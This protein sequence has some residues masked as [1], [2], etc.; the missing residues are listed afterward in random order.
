[1]SIFDELRTATATVA[2]SAGAAVVRVGRAG[3]RGAGIVTAPG[4]VVTS[5]HNVRGEELTVTFPGGREE[6]GAVKGVDADGDLAVVA[7]DTGDVAP[8][9][10]SD[11]EIGLGDTV[12]APVVPLGG[13]EVRVTVG[14]VSARQAAFRG[15][16]GRLISDAVE[17]TAPLGRG[18]SGGPLVDPEGRLVAINTH[19]PGGGLYLA[20]PVTADL[21]TRIDALARGESPARRRLGVALAPPHV[22][23][24]LR[25]AVGLEPRDGVLVREVAEGS[26]AAGAGVQRGDLIVA[27]GGD[28]VTSVDA[29][30]AAVDAG[31]TLALT[32]VRGAEEITVTVEWPP[33]TSGE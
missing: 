12:F 5:A 21:R 8:I 17:H 11:A 9:A 20:L 18:S 19:R 15:P 3:G 16:R 14:T 26:A 4:V 25:A 13:A 24:R 33:S 1:M 10:W 30:L 31:D 29:L 2:T 22:A 6:V 7:V 28:P 23:R 27:A 32:L